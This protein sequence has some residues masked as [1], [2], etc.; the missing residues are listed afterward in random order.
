MTD[1]YN[2][3]NDD[4]KGFRLDKFVE[5]Q[6][7]VPSIHYRFMGEYIKREGFD[8]DIAVE[9]CWYMACVYNEIGA[10]MIQ[11]MYEDGAT[12][13]YVCSRLN[14]IPVNSAKKYIRYKGRFKTMMD[15]FREITQGSPYLWLKTHSVGS[16]RKNYDSI[17][18]GLRGIVECGRFSAEL[19]ME[20]AS[21]LSDYLG[22]EL[23][24]SEEIDWRNGSNL[25]SGLFNMFYEDEKAIEYD[26]SKRVTSDDSKWLSERLLEVRSAIQARYP[27]QDSSVNSFVGKVCSFRN[28][29]KGTRYGGFHHDRQL[30]QINSLPDDFKWLAE[31]SFELRAEMFHPRFLGESCGWSGI[32]KEMKKLWLTKGLTGAEPNLTS[33]SST[34]TEARDGRASLMT[35]RCP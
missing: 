18:R 35:A 14:E 15:G 10:I 5:Y 19:F 3:P 31:K 21:Y 33:K 12:T 24:E 1:L 11:S 26:K 28:L 2:I 25:T 13:E 7:E 23:E 4:G 16:G 8:A 20:S 30:Q 32:R 29:F 27:S 22:V 17:T 6:N 34:A 9:M